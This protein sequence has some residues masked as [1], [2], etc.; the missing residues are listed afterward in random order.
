[1]EPDLFTYSSVLDAL[2][3]EARPGGAPVKVYC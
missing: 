2:A 1:M 3:V